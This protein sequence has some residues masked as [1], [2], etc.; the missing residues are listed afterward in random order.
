MP[1]SSSGQSSL[2]MRGVR[3][4]IILLLIGS[5]GFAA[6]FFYLG[7]RAFYETGPMNRDMVYELPKGQG[8]I[9]TAWELENLGLV[10]S[11][12]IFK[13]GV[14]LSGFERNLHAGEFAIPKKSSMFDIMMILSSGKVIEHRLTIVEGWTSWQITDYLNSIDNLS[15]P[16]MDL[17]REGSLLPDT[18]QYTKNTP[19]HDLIRMMQGRQ[20]DLMEGIWDKRAD[21]LPL[22]SMEDAL[23]LASIVEKETAVPHERAHIAG[24]FINRL[25]KNMRLQTDPTVIYGI[26]RKGFLDRPIYKSDLKA[27]NPYNTYKIRGLPPT[28][29]AHPGRASIEAVLN[30]LKTDDLY[31]VA[32]GTGGHAFAKTLREHLKNVKKWR[33]IE[34][35]KK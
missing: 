23:I 7:Y 4:Y 29:I 18:Y 19:R 5:A 10:S 27:D 34:K 35:K 8:V 16:I 24:V 2:L 20:M 21:D 25:R 14:K 28:A 11:Q 15:D 1:L 31:F 12:K 33:R 17:P 30:P 6:L 32:D 9:R 13:F 22:L 26:D 3:K